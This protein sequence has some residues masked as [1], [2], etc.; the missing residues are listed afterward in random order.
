M[1]ESSGILRNFIP[2]IFLWEQDNHA[3]FLTVFQIIESFT[4]RIT[5]NAYSFIQ[6]FRKRNTFHGSV[7]SQFNWVFNIFSNISGAKLCYT[8]DLC[9]IVLKK[10]EKL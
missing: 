5:L 2:L 1:H 4:C 3:F 8:H 9:T 10:Q 6:S 7:L